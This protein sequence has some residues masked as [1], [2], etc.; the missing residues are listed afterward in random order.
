MLMEVGGWDSRRKPLKWAVD[1]AGIGLPF[2][3]FLLHLH[4]DIKLANPG[5]FTPTV[6]LGFISYS[7]SYLHFYGY[8]P[9]SDHHYL[10]P[11][12]KQWLPLGFYATNAS[13]TMGTKD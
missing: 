9:N 2:A 7:I 1:A 3:L 5:Y 11:S 10:L 6:S 12:L 13:Y 8:C 4:C